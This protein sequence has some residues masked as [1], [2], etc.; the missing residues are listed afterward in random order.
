VA[1]LGHAYEGVFYSWRMHT[2]DKNSPFEKQHDAHAEGS[3]AAS[4]SSQNVPPYY[5]IVLRAVRRKAINKLKNYDDEQRLVDVFCI[6]SKDILQIVAKDVMFATEDKHTSL[7]NDPFRTDTQISAN[8]NTKE[9]RVLVKWE[10][11]EK[12]DPKSP[13]FVGE[14]RQSSSSSPASS[15]SNRNE[16]FDMYAANARFGVKSTYDENLYTTPVDKSDPELV[17]KAALQA[18]E[19]EKSKYMSDNIHVR[20][21]RGMEVDDNELDEESRYSTVLRQSEA[22]TSQKRG[23]QQTGGRTAYL[24]PHLRQSEQAP[25]AKTTTPTEQKKQTTEA[26]K[27]TAPP[28]AHV[29][30]QQTSAPSQQ[31]PV[32]KQDATPPPTTKADEKKPSLNPNAKEFTFNPNAKP[33]NPSHVQPPMHIMPPGAGHYPGAPYGHGAPMGMPP[34]G[35]M[36]P[37]GY[38]QGHYMPAPFA[39]APFGAPMQHP[40]QQGGPQPHQQHQH[41]QQQ[42]PNANKH[43]NGS[44]QQNFHQQH[45][46]PQH[47]Q[48]QP[49]GVH[50]GAVSMSMPHDKKT[51]I[52]PDNA[53][54]QRSSNP[55]Q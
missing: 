32:Q 8:S 12:Y 4:S 38:F 19:I 1:P 20:E 49:R 17:R 7:R 14:L 26:P 10:G 27:T 43:V 51:N 34:Y 54:P 2:S 42:T 24:P 33:F 39:G 55:K 11:D 52:R 36:P 44:M 21:D 28:T 5:S 31:P 40:P 16:P 48:Q 30:E 22:T 6:A 3:A 29:P 37:P 41:Q 25:P 18:Q 9:E 45:S 35:G 13:N 53:K 46:L 47:P 50:G 23:T 15:L